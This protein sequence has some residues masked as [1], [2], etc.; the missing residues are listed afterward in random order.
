MLF[1]A[2][3][4]KK[5]EPVITEELLRQ[6]MPFEPTTG[7]SRLFHVFAR[8]ANSVR[9]RCALLIRGY[10]GT[11]KTTCVQAMVSALE[12]VGVHAV[13]LAPTGRAAKV[14][15][16]Y[17]G[18]PASTIHREIYQ[19][20]TDR[21]G[22]VFF[23]LRENER[24]NTIF[25]VDEAS[26]IGTEAFARVNDEVASGNVLEDLITHVYTGGNCKL[27]LI[28]DTAQLPPVGSAES[29]ALN[30]RNLVREYDLNAAEVEL[31]EVVRQAGDSGI[32]DNATRIRNLIASGTASLPQFTTVG[33][34]DVIRI[35][36]DLESSLED[37]LRNYGQEDVMIITRSNKRA[38]LF[39]QQFRARILGYEEEINSGDR[40][41]VLRNNYY[42]LTENFPEK[43]GF[44]ANG[45]VILIE[46]IIRFEDRE[47]FRFCRARVSL[48]DF[49]D[50]PA[51]ETILLCNTIWSEGPS[52]DSQKGKELYQLISKDYEDQT[53]GRMRRSVQ[54]D[55]YY[56][57]LQVKFAYA[58]TCHKA[59]GGQ[60][61]SVFVD[62]GYLTD[63]MAGV[64]LNRWFYTAITR[65][66]K[67]LYLVGFSRDLVE[68]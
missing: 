40:M 23:D 17:C 54:A 37:A 34:G 55:P 12:S 51:F 16:A 68:E 33:P 65:A 18:R 3:D 58:V 44:I 11:G 14:M 62:Q 67:K 59:Q 57:A 31:T 45:D 27:V 2:A 39:N 36:S 28:G 30:L 7:Q 48:I 50:I 24:E 38:N 41:M 19:R 22:N 66:S 26:M 42:W 6:R 20:R 8:F 13:L 56:N 29:P 47:G 15:S 46:R 21:A 9:P 1:F 35:E 10:A 4:M 43:D 5:V 52:L 25:I 53:P 61:E 49:P 63:E 32:L 60:W 64:E